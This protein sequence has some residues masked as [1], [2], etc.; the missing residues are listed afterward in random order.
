[1]TTR[2]VTDRLATRA[3]SVPARAPARAPWPLDGC[4]ARSC[5]RGLGAV[6]AAGAAV[7]HVPVIEEHLH[8]APYIGVGFALLAIAGFLLACLLLTADTPRVWIATAAVAAV[9]LAGYMASR[10]VGL[11]QIHDDIGNWTD[12]LGLLAISAEA[13]MLVS[14]LAYAVEVL[15][16]RRRG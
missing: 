14:S 4:A 11:P 9:A 15:H 16:G 13:L 10:S 1:M 8:E 3:G 6:G 2:E 7:A 5:W 12:P